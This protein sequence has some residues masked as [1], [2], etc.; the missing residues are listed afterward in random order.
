ML[1]KLKQFKERHPFT[2]LM[3]IAIAVRIFVVIFVPGFGSN[4][5][6]QHP[7]LFIGF[8]D[9]MKSILGIGQ[10]QGM[11]LLSRALYAVVSLFTVSMVYRICDLTSNKQ[12]AWLL[13]LIPAFSCVMP[14][15]GVID[16]A[17]AFLGLPLLLYGSNV[18]LRQEV[19]RQNN[20]NENVHRTSFF[21]AGIVLGLGICFWF[22]SIF[23]VFSILVILISRRNYKGA[24]MTLIGTISSIVAVGL[25]LWILDVNPLKYIQL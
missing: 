23:I 19:L 8:L 10:S 14:A 20:L 9:K 22:E 18:V 4:R 2:T 1:Q 24:L 16:N 25:L 15:F 11:M 5:E 7:T 13:A 12:N 17:S 6:L 3:L 21:I